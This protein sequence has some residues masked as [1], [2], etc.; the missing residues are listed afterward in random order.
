MGSNL[1][2]TKNDCGFD[3]EFAVK[4]GDGEKVNLAGTTVKFQLSDINYINKINKDCII[5]DA[6]NGECKYTV[7][8]GDLNL[9][10]GLYRAALEITWNVNK[11]VSTNQFVVQVLNE[12][13]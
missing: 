4:N 5:T 1:S 9:T 2:V 13:G 11:K 3:I 10:A 8:T 6:V 12:C 7:S